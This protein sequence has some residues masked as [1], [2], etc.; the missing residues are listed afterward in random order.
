MTD[1]KIEIDRSIPDTK[2]WLQKYLDIVKTTLQSIFSKMKG[3]KASEAANKNIQLSINKNGYL[4]SLALLAI[5]FL[6]FLVLAIKVVT[7][8]FA[9]NKNISSLE[10]TTSYS[11]NV[12]KNSEFVTEFPKN[13]F[14]MIQEYNQSLQIKSEL[15]DESA[16]RTSI[17]THFLK[18]L[19]LPSL[20]IWKDPYGDS[21]DLS[22][23]GER[24]LDSDPYQ[25][26][27]LITQW[28]SII[29][30]SGKGVGVNDIMDMKIGDIVEQE[31]G[32]FY[33]PISVSFK[34]DSKRAFLLLVDKVSST[35]NPV[36]IGLIN[37]F[38]YYL[39]NAIRDQKKDAIQNL[40]Q[41]YFSGDAMVLNNF[42][43]E[44]LWDTNKL[45][46]NMA[47][48]RYLYYYIKWDGKENLL[49]DEEVIDQAIKESVVCGKDKSDNYCY[50]MFRNKYRSIPELSYA[51]GLETTINKVSALKSFFADIPPLIAIQSFTF[52]KAKSQG[53]I[54][55]D[56]TE[57]V[58]SM[59]FNV[60][61]KGISEDELNEISELLRESCFGTN[62]QYA[63]DA[64]GAL[65]R[66]D[67][68]LADIGSTENQKDA[69]EKTANYLQLKD[70]FS[71]DSNS[72][73]GLSQYNKVI[74]K[75]EYYRM[76]KDSNLCF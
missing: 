26:I 54:L 34:S 41:E 72:F 57:Y 73:A 75:F 52:D 51:I 55:N 3:S 62:T 12:F 9:L 35:S 23:I 70:I 2:G 45:Q 69:I 1:K 40:V 33:I 11:L 25:D 31:E 19:T 21:V 64:N 43:N 32:Y 24:Y 15:E 13:L 10:N 65:A 48:G 20:N 61:G 50:F 58:G 47:I 36:N 44:F 4:I 14:E 5:S 59:S 29:R 28:G 60:Y 30:D 74:K 68:A 53:L 71:A 76:L 22:L 66:V 17:Y 16:F 67:K 49:I 37:E 63:M 56:D 39:F 7:S 6:V 27:A 8:Y 46:E 18:H 38:T 42:G